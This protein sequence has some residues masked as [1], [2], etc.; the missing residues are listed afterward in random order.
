MSRAKTGGGVPCIATIPAS[1][2][3]SLRSQVSRSAGMDRA[4]AASSSSTVAAGR[5][6]T[7]CPS[8][9]SA[10][11]A[12]WHRSARDLLTRLK[13]VRPTPDLQRRDRAE[14]V[15]AMVVFLLSQQASFVNGANYRVDGGPVAMI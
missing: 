5:S 13:R 6:T 2:A 11:K 9:S 4:F 12:K 15:A 10:T 1:S 3:R 7:V 8:V 14:E